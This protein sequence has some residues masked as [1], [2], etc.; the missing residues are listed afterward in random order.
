[1]KIVCDSCGTKYSIADEKVRGKVFKIRCKKCSHII[2]VRGGESAPEA[3]A[4]ATEGGWHLVIDGE[5][6]GPLTDA[7][8]RTK[9]ERGE[10]KAD[11]YTWKEGFADWVKLS[12]VPEFAGLVAGEEMA[13]AAGGELFTASAAIAAPNGAERSRRASGSEQSLFGGGGGG[14]SDV[15]ASPAA[16]PARGPD[17]FGSSSAAPSVDETRWPSSGGVSAGHDGGR[18][19]NLTGQRH[20]NSVLFSLSNLQSLA[21]PSA[22][23]KPSVGS[24]SATPE[25]SGLI[26]IRA[27]AASTL[28]TSSNDRPGLPLGNAPPPDDLPAFGSFSPAAPVLLPLPS[29]SGPPKWLYVAGALMLIALVGIVG[30]AW[31]VLSAKPPVLV[32]TVQTVPAPAPPAPKAAPAEPAAKP[33]TIAD[34][35]LPPREG[36]AEATGATAA[37][38]EHEHEHEHEHHHG[39]HHEHEAVKEAKGQDKGPAGRALA[40]PP[41]PVAEKKPAKGSLDDLLDGAVRSRGGGGKRVSSDDDSGSKKP[42]A[43]STPLAKG[44]V[45]AGMNSVRPKISACYNEFKQKGMAMMNVVIGRNGKVSSATVSGKFA[46]TPTGAC[47]EKAVK[48]ASFPPSE[49]LT[50]QYPFMLQ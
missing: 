47:V 30:V 8:V 43:S 41:E 42:D 17:L 12:V 38:P 21:M 48:S 34:D 37:K 50:T 5:Q 4:P 18:V 9:V 7:D 22:A 3:A 20:E 23:P 32:E 25:G 40:P 45:V 29:S 28:G 1:M 39:G 31:K 33:S 14:V 11:T 49:G 19:E 35:K 10:I 24:T 16:A 2:V 15:F 6:V 46:G 26:D 27:M 36:S 13:V 44:A